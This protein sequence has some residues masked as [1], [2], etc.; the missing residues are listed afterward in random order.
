M[1]SCG[2]AGPGDGAER[3]SN[4]RRLALRP[5]DGALVLA[6][7]GAV[8]PIIVAASRA[9]ARGWL[10]VGD[11]AY[12]A[13]RG[14]D[15]F[16]GHP[17][18]LGTWSSASLWAH[19]Q[20]NHPGPLQFDAAS[21]PVRLFGPGAGVAIATAGANVAAV[22]A[23]ALL[24]R[25]L[26]GPLA[27]TVTMVFTAGL[28]WAMGSEVLFDPWSQHAP[29]LPFLAFL[30]AVWVVSA[31]QAAAWPVLA[32]AGSYAMEVHLSYAVLV[33]GLGCWALVGWLIT[34][35]QSKRTAPEQWDAN[36]H[37]QKRW[38]AVGL[39]CIA[40]CWAQPLYQ[41]LTGHVGNLSELARSAA[42]NGPP[43]PGPR[44]AL[45]MVVTVVGTP[46]FWFPPA[47]VRPHFASRPL[48]LLTLVLITVTGVGAA[49]A[50]LARRAADRASVAGLITA[51]FAVALAFIS[52]ASAKSSF[53]FLTASYVR[54]LWPISLFAWT[55]L[56]IAATRV[57]QRAS[58]YGARRRLETGV[59]AG[60]AVMAV[61]AG[62]AALPTANHG[63][64]S[65]YWA[66]RATHEVSR[67]ALPA[68]ESQGRVLVHLQSSAGWAVGAA[69][70][71]E[72]QRKGIEFVVDDPGLV[73]QLGQ[74]RRYDGANARTLVTVAGGDGA[75]H[76][77]PGA[78]LVAYAPALG[79]AERQVM[80]KLG[81][82]I[83]ARVE[84]HHGVPLDHVKLAQLPLGLGSRI[85][86]NA[87]RPGPLD[88]GTISGLMKQHLLDDQAFG[89]VDVG[90][91]ASLATRWQYETVA[92]FAGPV[93]A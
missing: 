31:G 4:G 11:D 78:K 51:A 80:L 44:T 49:L 30:F 1:T 71:V 3:G 48:W 19:H 40:L 6:A 89:D 64:A 24:M 76:P 7:L 61:A 15:V 2:P 84:A 70:M 54:W 45:R 88:P 52:V 39:V 10:P 75:E 41:Q 35:R 91:W 34:L 85:R 79:R 81:A 9:V 12:T 65:P 66:I 83:K 5:A 13:I 62:V 21:I 20:I 50:W 27:A 90:R 25:Y 56:I 38:A 74:A 87:D 16:G 58:R 72:L 60:L 37:R 32:V 73:S 46:P 77:P 55:A 43:S 53:G 63:A 86:A 18:L 29:I 28:V 93:P 47:W 22:L 23:A 14:R 68:L 82:Q 57:A 8:T 26:A 17:P 33:P 42:V 67:Q 92:V 59:G 36:W 69:L